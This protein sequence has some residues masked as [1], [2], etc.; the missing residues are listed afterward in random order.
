MYGKSTEVI[1]KDIIENEKISIEWNKPST[2]VDFEFEILNKNQTYVTIKH[3]GCNN[4]GAQL[5]ES[6]KNNTGGFTTVLDGLK[7]FLEH[8]INL[9]LIADKYSQKAK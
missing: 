9:N 6:I 8:G 3:Y 7:A 4:T 2:C 1:V 5:I